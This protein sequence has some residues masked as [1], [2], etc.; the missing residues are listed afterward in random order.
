MSDDSI[1][2]LHPRAS[3]FALAYL[4]SRDRLR[5]HVEAA[6]LSERCKENVIPAMIHHCNESRIDRDVRDAGGQSRSADV[7]DGGRGR[8]GRVSENVLTVAVSMPSANAFDNCAPG[9]C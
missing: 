9:A 7:F 5:A 6:C 3:T 8:F 1:V 2:E 4:E